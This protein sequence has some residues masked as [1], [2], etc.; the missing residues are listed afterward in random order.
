[1]PK[2]CCLIMS[3]LSDV[4][5]YFPPH[6][7]LRVN[8]MFFMLPSHLTCANAVWICSMLKR[9]FWYKNKNYPL[10][11]RWGNPPYTTTVAVSVYGFILFILLPCK[12]HTS[13]FQLV[14][15]ALKIHIFAKFSSQ[16]LLSVYS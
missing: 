8:I 12:N 1:M 9:N 7:A 6:F 13:C 15:L 11:S 14:T 16:S 4:A 3:S 5:S 10:K 2:P